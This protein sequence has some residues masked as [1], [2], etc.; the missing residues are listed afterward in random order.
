MIEDEVMGP[1]IPE[2]GASVLNNILASGLNEQATR[3]RK[4][5]IHRPSNSELLAQTRV[6]SEIWDDYQEADM[7][8]GVQA[9]S[10]QDT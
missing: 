10:L 7:K 4:E 3:K 2:K 9:T 8:H 1:S 5:N 6:N